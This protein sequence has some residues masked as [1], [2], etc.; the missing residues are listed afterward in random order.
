MKVWGAEPL[1]ICCIS[2]EKMSDIYIYSL[3]TTTSFE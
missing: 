3:L 1:F 2:Y